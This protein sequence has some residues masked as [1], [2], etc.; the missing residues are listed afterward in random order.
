M[1][2][3]DTARTVYTTVEG[4]TEYG[5]GFQ[6][7]FNPDDTPQLKVKLGD[8]LL[9]YG[10]D[11]LVS[12]NELNIVL[13][14]EP[15]A[16]LKVEITRNIPL[17]QTS[18]YVIGRIDPDQIERDFD[19]AVMRDQSEYERLS[20]YATKFE[21]EIADLQEN[22]QDVI[23]DLDTIRSGA[24]AGATALQP[25]DLATVATTGSYNDLS[26]KPTIPDV[27]NMQLKSNLVTSVSA[28]STDVQYPSAKLFYDTCGDIE[29]LI[30]AL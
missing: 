22:K 9:V 27:S 1:V 19:L 4:V 15:E 8:Q 29:T 2:N 30:N 3:S 23:D 26:D 18:D 20:G 28:A 10:D 24:A 17:T 13:S 16:G 25:T 12:E 11:Y 6:Y 14:E 5:I 21:S 7:Y